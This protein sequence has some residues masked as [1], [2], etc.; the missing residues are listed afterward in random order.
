MFAVWPVLSLKGSV[1][2]LLAGGRPPTQ[3]Q[4][5]S[6]FH[7]KQRRVT[8]LAATLRSARLQLGLDRLAGSR[9]QFGPLGLQRFAY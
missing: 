9:Q 3:P 5:R 7:V 1:L 4:A 6:M 8:P 2:S